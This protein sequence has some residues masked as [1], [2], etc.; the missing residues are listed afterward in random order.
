VL[1]PVLARGLPSW[2]KKTPCKRKKAVWRRQG[3]LRQRNPGVPSDVMVRLRVLARTGRVDCRRPC[4]SFSPSSG[5]T[6]MPIL[7]VARWRSARG[8]IEWMCTQERWNPEVAIIFGSAV[9]YRRATPGSSHD[10]RIRITR[11]C[12]RGRFTS[13]PT[14]GE[15]LLYI[16][17]CGPWQFTSVRNAASF[18]V[19]FLGVRFSC[20]G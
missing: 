14:C 15:P 8:M 20:G 17:P 4:A 12:T 18:F 7:C 11:C 13:A 9:R 1:R 19:Y 16:V 10:T 5:S 2:A 6:A 3:S